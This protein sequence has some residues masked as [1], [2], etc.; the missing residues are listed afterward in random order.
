[1]VSA[2]TQILL[3]HKIIGI[4]KGERLI[5]DKM[6]HFY[7][8]TNSYHVLLCDSRSLHMIGCFLPKDDGSPWVCPP[9][10]AASVF[11]SVRD[12]REG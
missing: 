8:F 7:I 12:V 6:C 9:C 11:S 5:P 2:T 4:H 1:M 10:S 3:N